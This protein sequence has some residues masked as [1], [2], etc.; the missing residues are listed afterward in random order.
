MT[1]AGTRASMSALD[2]R[3]ARLEDEFFRGAGLGMVTRLLRPGPGDLRLRVHEVGRGPAVLFL[4]PAAFFGAHWVPVLRRLDGCR[5]LAVDLPG[6]GLSD[7]VDYRRVHPRQFTVQ[8]LG[9]LLDRLGL[10]EVTVVGSSL[11]GLCALWLASEAPGRIARVMV[12][13]TP[14]TALPGVQADL[15]LRLLATPGL[16]RRAVSLPLPRAVA[17]AFLRHAMGDRALARLPGE[18]VEIYRLAMR[19]PAW[20]LTVPSLMERLL[21]GRQASPDMV[22]PVEALRAIRVPTLFLWGGQDVYGPPV[23]ARRAAA[24]LP[25]AEVVIWDRAGHLPQCDEPEAFA[26]LV[27]EFAGAGSAPVSAPV[28]VPVSG[29]PGPVRPG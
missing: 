19:R 17:R 28:P 10:E 2:L 13:G 9:A 7:G 5:C 22:L 16:N 3:I 29:S 8:W 23:M 27:A 24:I 25:H 15:G 4:H 18:V 20:R 6:H 12:V 11:G 26:R 21:V 1:D 14:A